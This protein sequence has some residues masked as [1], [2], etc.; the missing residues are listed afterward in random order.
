MTVRV[1]LRGGLGNQL[2]QYAAGVALADR[3]GSPLV[4]DT[5]LLPSNL[6]VSGTVS[7]WPEQ[8]S[9]FEHEGRV[10]HIGSETPLLKRFRAGFAGLERQL[11]D[12]NI[13][14]RRRSRVYAR[15]NGDDLKQF[16]ALDRNPRVNAYCLEPR[17]FAGYESQIRASISRPV[18]PTDWFEREITHVSEVR[19]II[20]HIRRGDFLKLGHIY[21][22]LSPKF[23]VRAVTLLTQLIGGEREIWL[24]S[25]DPG[26]AIEDVCE[27]LTISRVI[28]APPSSPPIEALNVLASGSGLVAANSTFSWWAAFL[29][30][31]NPDFRAVFPRPLFEEGALPEPKYFLRDDWIQIG[32]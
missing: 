18:T 29:G 1:Q 24:S 19:P 32:R 26:G 9:T 12:V 3:L 30:D 11:A 15:E 27:F 17:F 31:I 2:F 4:F 22:T 21:G 7:R 13:R 6:D 16:F 25:D 23:Y 10:T 14:F 5:S 20:L 8:I 28:E